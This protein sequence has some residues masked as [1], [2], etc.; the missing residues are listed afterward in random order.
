MAADILDAVLGVLLAGGKARRM[1]GG[2]KSMLILG[3]RPILEAII[4]RVRPQVGKLI[5]NANGDAER[6][7]RFGLPVVPDVIEGFAGPLAGVLTGMEWSAGNAPGLDWVASF[8]TDAP[9]LPVDMVDRLT[10]AIEG[11][12]ADI[13][14]AKSRGR[15]HPV[16]ALWPVR[17]RRE[18]R[19][20]MVDEEMRK[21]DE[22][23]ARYRVAHVA[24]EGEPDPFF[25]INRPDNLAEAET[26]LAATSGGG[27][28]KE[29]AA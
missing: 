3:G 20:A 29:G 15:A 19:R 16:F 8:A 12:G 10:A 17:L 24:F 26:I 22:W 28:L 1:G 2:D 21:I 7:V 14:C 25:N 18:L 11:R 9:F 27:E 5:I 4:E 13:A 23:T 6:F